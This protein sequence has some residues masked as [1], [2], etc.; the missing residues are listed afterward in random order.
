MKKRYKGVTYTLINLDV[1]TASKYYI[2]RD[3][4]IIRQKLGV[5][6]E[7]KPKIQEGTKLLEVTVQ[8]TWNHILKRSERKVYTYN[9][10]YA[11]VFLTG[12]YKFALREIDGI[13]KWVTRKEYADL[14][15]PR[16]QQFRGMISNKNCA[17]KKEQIQ[18]I[19]SLRNSGLN[20]KRI[21]DKYGCSEMSISR[22]LKRN[23]SKIN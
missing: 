20:N 22:A 11:K 3:N 1:N 23:Y 9:Q 15:S 10:I 4:N 5:I 16:L 18:E 7:M 2:S 17:I 6:H 21:T 14:N 13:P 8:G 19:K 12:K